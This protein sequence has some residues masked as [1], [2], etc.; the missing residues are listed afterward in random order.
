[1]ESLCDIKY[2]VCGKSNRPG[3][4]YVAPYIQ[5]V[6]PDASFSDI[7]AMVAALRVKSGFDWKVAIRD[8][9]ADNKFTP[10]DLSGEIDRQLPTLSVELY[11]YTRAMTA[12]LR[13]GKLPPYNRDTSIPSDKTPALIYAMILTC[14]REYQMIMPVDVFI[15]FGAACKEYYGPYNGLP[16]GIKRALSAHTQQF[17]IRTCDDTEMTYARCM[18]A[19][20]IGDVKISPIID[21]VDIEITLR[22]TSKFSE[23]LAMSFHRYTIMGRDMPLVPDEPNDASTGAYRH[24]NARVQSHKQPHMDASK[25]QR[26]GNE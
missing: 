13:D 26:L 8:V 17:H 5:P 24:I 7:K 25:G 21:C 12:A 15:A 9:D 2:V 10:V 11:Q 3:D 14:N 4:A 6:R 20:R 1:M 23:I 18:S 16:W 22:E 19:N